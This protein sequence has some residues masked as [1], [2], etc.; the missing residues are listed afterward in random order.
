M[1]PTL[2]SLEDR[3]APAVG[4]VGT[5]LVVVGTA[6]NDTIIVG[7]SSVRFNG[8]T[9]TFDPAL[10]DSVFVQ[11]LGGNDYL[12]CLAHSKPSFIDGGDGDDRIWGSRG[13]D[14]ILGGAGDDTLRGWFG[15]D[16]IIGGAGA[17]EL[18]GGYGVDSLFSDADDLVVSQD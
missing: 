12:S 2:E 14:T 16:A 9:T 10:V 3:L 17:D 4:I 15:D 13:N 11:G 18:I 6:A 5:T 7:Q 1:K 8:V